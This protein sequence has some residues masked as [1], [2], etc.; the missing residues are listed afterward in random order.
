M[1]SDVQDLYNAMDLFVL[2]SYYEGLPV[3][4]VECQANGLPIVVSNRVT[5]ELYISDLLSFLPLENKYEW[6][7]KIEEKYNFKRK[8]VD[9][10]LDE[11]GFNICKEVV[12]LMQ[13]YKVWGNCKWKKCR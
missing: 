11:C 2:P 9:K 8:D 6:I 5:D 10:E 3:V 1:R 12:I 4:G 7:E 13:L